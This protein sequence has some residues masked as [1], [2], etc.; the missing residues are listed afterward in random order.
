MKCINCKKGEMKQNYTTYYKKVGDSYI[1]IENVPCM[2]CSFCGEISYSV[3]T[4]ESLERMID[5]VKIAEKANI[6][7]YDIAA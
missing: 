5:K 7:E 6:I 4:L 2:I 3:K 1:I